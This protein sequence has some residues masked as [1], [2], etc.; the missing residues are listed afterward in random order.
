MT[1]SD[2]ANPRTGL[3]YII[4]PHFAHN[5]KW[6]LQK[7]CIVTQNFSDFSGFFLFSGKRFTQNGFET[8]H[9]SQMMAEDT[10]QAYG[11]Y[12]CTG[13]LDGIRQ[14]KRPDADGKCG[15]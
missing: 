1:N 15:R 7:R 9:A 11:Q 12:V 14:D 13:E 6:F 2:R 4:I 3:L 8:C 5:F 10:P